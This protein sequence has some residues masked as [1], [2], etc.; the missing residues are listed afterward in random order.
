MLAYITKMSNFFKDNAFVLLGTLAFVSQTPWAQEWLGKLGSLLSTSQFAHFNLPATALLTRAVL[1]KKQLN[2][3]FYLWL[4]SMLFEYNY[5]VY[6]GPF[7]NLWPFGLKIPW[8]SLVQMIM[9]VSFTLTV[10]SK[11]LEPPKRRVPVEEPQWE[12]REIRPIYIVSSPAFGP[13]WLSVALNSAWIWV[14]NSIETVATKFLRNRYPD[15]AADLSEDSIHIILGEISHRSVIPVMLLCS[16]VF[17]A[18]NLF[19]DWLDNIRWPL[20]Y[21]GMVVISLAFI[22]RRYGGDTGRLW[23]MQQLIYHQAIEVDGWYYELSRINMLANSIDLSVRKVPHPPQFPDRIILS[24]EKAGDT[25]FTKEE[26]EETGNTPASLPFLGLDL[27]KLTPSNRCQ[28][29]N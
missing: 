3:T 23:P 2:L 16:T 9:I 20:N 22:T 29:A 27:A 11:S 25:F 21:F 10:T 24:R 4:I 17:Q 26:I 6:Q 5:L 18:I 1:N 13:P 8:Q 12:E 7:V 15:I 14:R 19:T 28:H